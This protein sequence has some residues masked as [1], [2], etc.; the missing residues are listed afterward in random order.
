MEVNI[1]VIIPVY[2]TKLYLREAIESVI[3]QKE[4]VHEIIIINDGSTDGSGELLEKLYGEQEFIKILH[5]ENNGQGHARNLGIE[6]SNGNYIYFF[7]SDDILA[8]NLFSI[9]FRTLSEKRD[10]ELYCFSGESFLDPNSSIDK[11]SGGKT[12]F[13]SRLGRGILMLIVKQVKMHSTY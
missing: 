10:L 2:N 12:N 9:F 13:L 6:L 5:T 8:P 11:I 3:D 7:D 4:F 1:S